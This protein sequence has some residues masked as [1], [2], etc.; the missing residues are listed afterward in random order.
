[1]I[2]VRVVLLLVVALLLF[3]WAAAWAGP[4][5]APNAAGNSNVANTRHGY[6]SG[7]GP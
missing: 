6:P 3:W 7:L 2:R 1:M 5:G 4:R